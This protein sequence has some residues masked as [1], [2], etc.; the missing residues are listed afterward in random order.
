MNIINATKLIAKFMKYCKHGK[1]DLLHI[2]YEEKNA[3]L[4]EA[5][6]HRSWEWLMP[7]VEKIET[8]LSLATMMYVNTWDNRGR[9]IF[10]IYKELDTDG[11]IRDLLIERVSNSKKESIWLAVVAF[12]E[13]YN[14]NKDK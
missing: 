6:Y 2:C 13:W 9:Y 11:S 7:V 5:N 4:A 8:D 12:I 1:E 10:R 14:K 3:F